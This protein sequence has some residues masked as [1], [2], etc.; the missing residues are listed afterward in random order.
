MRETFSGVFKEPFDQS[1]EVLKK[2]ESENLQDEV[3]EIFK[4]IIL[5]KGMYFDY[6]ESIS[7]Q[8]K[9]AKW[10]ITVVYIALILLLV[11]ITYSGFIVIGDEMK[12]MKL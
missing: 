11:G 1:I 8:T 10:K 9:K 5:D 7:T 12:D 4:K 2:A 6:L 3:V